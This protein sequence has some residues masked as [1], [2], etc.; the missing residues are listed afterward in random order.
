MFFW[1]KR[2]L[3]TKNTNRLWRCL[4]VDSF[5]AVVLNKN[6]ATLLKCEQSFRHHGGNNNKI[7]YCTTRFRFRR[8]SIKRA[9]SWIN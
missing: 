2:P 4:L 8:A 7:L 6:L 9:R 5:Q 1:T 3:T